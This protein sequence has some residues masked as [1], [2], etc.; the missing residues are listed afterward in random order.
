M[1]CF[2]C[3]DVKVKVV[4]SKEYKGR[5]YRRRKC[6]KCGAEFFT[7]EKTCT[8]EEFN[9]ARNAYDTKHKDSWY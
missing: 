6:P 9:K 4:D 3:E 8:K 7:E 1:N 2:Y 5:I